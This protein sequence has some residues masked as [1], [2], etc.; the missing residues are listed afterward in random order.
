MKKPIPKTSPGIP[1]IK[2]TDSR[3]WKKGKMTG[4]SG[5]HGGVENYLF[6]IRNYV[7]LM[8]EKFYEAIFQ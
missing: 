2:I 6:M 8:I 4:F 3:E 5:R 7:I 1:G